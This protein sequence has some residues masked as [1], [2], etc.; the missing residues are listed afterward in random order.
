MRK[1]F[2][3]LRSSN[4]VP[5]FLLVPLYLCWDKLLFSDNNIV[6]TILLCH[7][8]QK[9]KKQTKPNQLH[10]KNP[11]RIFTRIPLS[12]PP[13]EVKDQ[14]S[15]CY[16]FIEI[17]LPNYH[18]IC[19]FTMAYL[20]YLGIGY[21]IEKSEFLVNIL[22]S[23]GSRYPFHIKIVKGITTFLLSTTVLPSIKILYPG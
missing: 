17:Q 9:I 18:K 23:M 4:F 1:G 5:S 15:I 20:T 22:P 11:T 12:L 6:P 8:T 2:C 19:L 14:G 16:T 10:K 3:S 13:T 21:V 7:L